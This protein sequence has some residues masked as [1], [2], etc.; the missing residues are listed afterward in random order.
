MLVTQQLEMIKAQCKALSPLVVI[1]CITYNH[2][3]YIRD[4]LEGFVRQKTKFA[5]VAI[6]HDDAS[7]DDTALIIREY[8]KKYPDII[9]PI[10]EE[11]NQYSKRDGSLTRIMNEA[12]RATGAKYVA[13]CEGDDYW[14]DPLKL[15]K[16]VDFLE[17]NPKYGMCYTKVQR[18]YQRFSKLGEIW[19][20][21][22]VT[23][24]DLLR[25]NTIP[26]LTTLFRQNLVELYYEEI[27]PCNKKWKMGDY[28]IWLFFAHESKIK[29]IDEVTGIYRVLD[30]SASH[31]KDYIKQLEFSN[32]SYRIKKYMI[33]YFKEEYPVIMNEINIK[34][35]YINMRIAILNNQ[36]S[37][38]YIL[39]FRHTF[40]HT[41]LSIFQRLKLLP[42]VIWPK[43]LSKT[44]Y[45]RFS[46]KL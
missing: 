31:C 10:Y 37:D 39:I 15:Q 43:F 6:V 35:S 29:F 24:S 25:I 16:Q 40:W 14:I 7:T 13:I 46:A 5:F 32:S 3:P 23:F 38:K 4:T 22:N 1:N 20:G 12:C 44:A 9:K 18:Y 30:N 36:S 28:P 19:G 11:E 17:A 33:E 21:D 41:S 26:T 34:E 8:A 2:E 45:K 27:N 42:W